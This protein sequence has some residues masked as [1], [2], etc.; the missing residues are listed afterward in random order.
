LGQSGQSSAG[1]NDFQELIALVSLG[2]VGLILGYEVSRLARNNSDWY[3]LLDL[4][5]VFGT[6]IADSDGLYDPRLYND[7]LLLGLKGTMS[8]AELH[9]LRL[10]LDAGR[11]SQVRRGEYV[12][13]LPTG[14]VRRPDGQ[15]VK[16]PDDQVRHTLE[17]VFAKFDEL[18]SG[19][20]LLRYLSGEKILLA[21]RQ[22][23]GLH[24]G[25][26]LWKRP[27]LSAIYEILENPAYAGAFAYGR[28]PGD[29]TRRQPSRPA[30]GQ[31]R[32]P[33]AEWLYLKRDVYPAYISWEKY[34]E[35]QA[36]LRDNMVRY[37]RTRCPGRGAPR[38]G[39]A[40]L[41]GLVI[42]G[43]CGHQMRVQYKPA[44]RYFCNALSK[45]YGQKMC[46][47][48]GGP[49]IDAVVVQAFFAAIQPSQLDALEAALAKQQADHAQLD[50]YWQERVHRASYEAHFARRQYDA[51]D[52]DNRLVAAELERRWEEKLH[53]LHA[54]Q[55]EYARFRHEPGPPSLSPELRSQ[56]QHISERLPDLWH[57]GQLTCAQKKSLLRS[58]IARVILKRTA[59][60]CIEARIVWV[61]GHFSICTVRPPI[62][63]EC[64]VMGYTEMVA[65]IRQL[66]EL[67]LSDEQ[68]AAQLTRE[69]FHSARSPD[70]T[71]KTV[72]KVRL[73]HRWY[74]TLH[75]SRGA[76]E[77]YGYLTATGL[78]QRIGVDR[79]WVYRRLEQGKIDPQYVKREPKSGIYLIA[80]DERLI[81]CLR[82]AVHRRPHS[83]GGI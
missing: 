53:E 12:Q 79:S 45:E 34:L 78:A 19:S 59:P 21:R 58:L 71:V 13:V 64:D 9:L 3:R 42:C 29:P 60:D 73:Q 17:L 81:E 49:S 40:L 10:R 51:V 5:A 74:D 65:R 72:L 36:R 62:W 31:V 67:G 68:I 16:D 55:E 82:Q 18:A 24:K 4:A 83:D 32:K 35:I 52:P 1:R 23:G 15:V 41:Q 33:M 7:R 76:T 46:C 28:R 66:W 69:G 70:V 6:L 54:V 43:H 56:L 20:R 44:P 80:N 11:L 77:L 27:T 61:S 48:L 22:T 47:S 2:Q 75:Q 57:S 39:Q 30:T 38:E 14:L 37:A 26:L 8:E 63:R 50:R 25:E